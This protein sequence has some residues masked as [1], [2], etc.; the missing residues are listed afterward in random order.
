[1][2]AGESVTIS[3]LSGFN[4]GASPGQIEIELDKVGAVVVIGPLQTLT[5]AAVISV[6]PVSHEGSDC[7]EGCGYRQGPCSWCGSGMCCR[8]GW[9]DTSGCDGTLGIDETRH[10]CVPTPSK[11]SYGSTALNK[12]LWNCSKGELILPVIGIAIENVTYSIAW[13]VVNADCCRTAK[14]VYIT[15]SPTCFKNRSSI[16][17]APLYAELQ[18]LHLRC[19]NFSASISQVNRNPCD[20]SNI[21][22][23]F[24][25]N[26]PVAV[27]ASTTSPAVQLRG[28]GKTL[29]G[30][31]QIV[32]FGS[33]PVVGSPCTSPRHSGLFCANFTGSGGVL[34]API[35]RSL[36]GNTRYTI[37]FS[38]VNPRIP[39]TQASL[40]QMRIVNICGLEAFATVNQTAGPVLSPVQAHFVVK[41]IGQST[42]WP[43]ALNTI[44]ISISANVSLGR[45]RDQEY[46]HSASS[47][48][49]QCNFTILIEGFTGVCFDSE[50]LTPLQ[51]DSTDNITMD[52]V[53]NRNGPSVLLKPQYQFVA[54]LVYKISFEVRNPAAAQPSPNFYIS[55]S[56]IE[57][58]RTQMNK[59]NSSVPDNPLCGSDNGAIQN[60]LPFDAEPLRVR[61]PEFLIRKI[62]QSDPTPGLATRPTI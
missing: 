47:R 30:A 53:F 20:D 15:A 43:G 11:Y 40:I 13:S 29:S 55:S 56:G 41:Q 9:N 12:T 3:G 33:D 54:G 27:D 32:I 51:I 25:L 16:M 31:G 58:A 44:T 39:Q 8:K 49:A 46:F 26:G 34:T 50:I 7:L 21:S 28:F 4:C 1:M 19:L 38:L 22:L 17:S 35:R 23:F 59:D 18:P 6:G 5:A 36:L 52:G 10:V 45:K 14:P 42:P 60:S 48:L 24:S 57:I 37:E 61:A 62:G 2:T